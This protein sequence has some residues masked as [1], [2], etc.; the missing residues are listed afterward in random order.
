MPVNALYNGSW[1]E[2][3]AGSSLFRLRRDQASSITRIAGQAAPFSGT[4]TRLR[5]RF[6]WPD[7]DGLAPDKIPSSLRTL[8]ITISADVFRHCK[9]TSNTVGTAGIH[10]L[11]YEQVTADMSIV[12][13]LA[14]DACGQYWSPPPRRVKILTSSLRAAA[15]QATG[16][17]DDKQATFLRTV[18][19]II[20]HGVGEN[21]A[22][23]DNGGS[24]SG[25]AACDRATAA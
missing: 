1:I 5:W 14:C 4:D 11:R 17:G 8:D 23:D 22:G 6:P 3:G 15:V 10:H 25:A 18:A 7:E 20:S 9:T 21:H 12:P 2:V 16:D 24:G 19:A 13:V